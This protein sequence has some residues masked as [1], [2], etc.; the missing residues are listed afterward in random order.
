MID[1]LAQ[2]ARRKNRTLDGHLITVGQPVTLDGTSATARCHFVARSPTGQV[3]VRKLARKLATQ[4]VE[5]CIPPTSIAEAREAGSTEAVL[6]L[7]AQAQELF[8]TLDQSGEGGELLLYL[9][10]EVVLELPQLLCKMSLKT[11][12]AMHVHGADGIHG[13]VLPDGA[14][15]LY[16]G[17]SKLHAN[18]ATA[19]DSCFE[20]LEPFLTDDGDGRT[21]RDLVLLRDGLDLSNPRLVEALRRYLC[22]DTVESTNVQ[23]RGAA[24]VGFDLADY[25]TPYE[26]DDTTITNEV[27]EAIAVW[28]KRIAHQVG[29]RTLNNFHIEVFCVPV[30]SVDALRKEVRDALRLGT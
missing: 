12:S 5:Y 11:N 27:A 26:N 6:A 15:A 17:E 28:Q 20:S 19:I 8:T 29:K 3:L 1:A 21:R 4:I 9:L 2:E 16:W 30:P 18:P 7:Q 10:L 22:E 24:L 13:A 25:P 14:L 23:F